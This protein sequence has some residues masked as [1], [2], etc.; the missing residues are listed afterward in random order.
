MTTDKLGEINKQVCPRCVSLNG[1]REFID[2]LKELYDEDPKKAYDWLDLQ[3]INARNSILN[4]RTYDLLQQGII[5][6]P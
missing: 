5:E 6:L 1:D 2:K 3:L 4:K